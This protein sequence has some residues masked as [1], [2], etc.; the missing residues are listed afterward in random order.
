M[1][2]GV[3]NAADYQ[4]M[5]Y[6][7]QPDPSWSHTYHNDFDTYLASDWTVTVVGTGTAA[8]AA[9]D[10]GYLVLT[11][12]GGATDSVL[13]Q[14]K[15]ASF[16]ALPG[17]DV[18]FKALMVAYSDAITDTIHAGL[19]ATSTTPLTAADGV[20]L[21]KAN[22]V[23]TWTLNAVIGGVTVSAAF[24]AAQG[25]VA[26]VPMEVG[27]HIDYLGNI[28]GFINP[29]T[30]ADWQQLDPTST[31]TGAMTVR[32]RSAFIPASSLPNGITQVLLNASFGITNGNATVHTLGVD[33]ITAVRN[34]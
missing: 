19:I 24:P 23:N 26:G 18:F 17:K 1:A 6:A 8:L 22:G 4:T 33:Y 29:T 7:G 31:A 13:M 2:N 3:T 34:R 16:K 9:T 21:S 10:G 20:F 11:T 32:G 27:F 25:M 5:A 14:L 15:A 28:E 30:G 12:T